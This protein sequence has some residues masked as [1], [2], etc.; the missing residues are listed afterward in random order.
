MRLL[1]KCVVADGVTSPTVVQSK[2]RVN[3]ITI[4]VKIVRR[5]VSN[6]IKCI[7]TR[8]PAV[9]IEANVLQDRIV[10]KHVSTTDEG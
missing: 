8:S 7:G 3:F 10:W 1:V 6:L 4:E 9:A 5:S 2:R